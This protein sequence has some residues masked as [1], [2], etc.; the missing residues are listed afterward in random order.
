LQE[1]VELK[2]Q[3]AEEQEKLLRE[4]YISKELELNALYR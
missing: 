4:E 3:Q 1:N 2:V